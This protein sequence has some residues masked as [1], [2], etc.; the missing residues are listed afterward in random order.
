MEDQRQ[1][2][3]DEMLGRKVGC[4]VTGGLSSIRVPD[5]GTGRGLKQSPQ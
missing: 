2:G 3:S 5:W 4:I 1:R